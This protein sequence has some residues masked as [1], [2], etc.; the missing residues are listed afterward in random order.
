LGGGVFIDAHAT[1]T[2]T[3]TYSRITYNEAQGGAGGAR[4]GDGHS[5][6][7]AVYIAADGIACKDGAT[8]STDNEASTSN[9]DVFGVFTPCPRDARCLRVRQ[10]A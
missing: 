1:L 3:L 10:T 2:L 8:V 5:I 4:F 6:S 7:G 9:A